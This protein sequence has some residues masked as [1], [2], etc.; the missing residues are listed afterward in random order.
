MSQPEMPETRPAAAPDTELLA[1]A[2]R[3]YANAYAPYS[4]FH[5]GA[6]LRTADGRTYAGANVE[7]ASY[8]LGRC[9][10]QSAVQALASDGGRDFSEVLVYSEAS[11]PAS[12]CGACRQVLFEFAPEASV[13]CVNH[14]GE[15]ISGQV[16]DFLPH[17]FRLEEN[18][19]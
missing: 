6:A 12:P 1:L 2:R 4:R 13:T 15:V 19:R 14:L 11:P 8:G 17:G 16:K 18:K 9:A 5:V 7:N 3:A 10:E